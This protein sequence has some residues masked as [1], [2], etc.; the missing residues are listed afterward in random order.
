[1][2]NTK[3]TRK[4]QTMKKQIAIAELPADLN[5][6]NTC[7]VAVYRLNKDGQTTK[8]LERFLVGNHAAAVAEADALNTPAAPVSTGDSI[9]IDGTTWIVDASLKAS[10][11]ADE[12]PALYASVWEPEGV[13]A[14]LLVKRPRGRKQYAATQF[15]TGNFSRPFSLGR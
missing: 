7:H 13:I 3:T 4:A 9:E 14:E 12:Y 6:P 2:G 8:R 1:M 10:E 15:D 5:D 11:Y